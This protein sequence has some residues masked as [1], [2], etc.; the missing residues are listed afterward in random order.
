MNRYG[1]T[2]SMEV[3][4]INSNKLFNS[5]NVLNEENLIELLD[6]YFPAFNTGNI[7]DF[8]FNSNNDRI[9]INTG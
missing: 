7:A 3:N 2:N 8:I 9:G 4:K 5:T 6:Y 1:N